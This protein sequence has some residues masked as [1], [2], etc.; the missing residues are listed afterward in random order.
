VTLERSQSRLGFHGIIIDA[1]ERR[2]F[3]E[4]C[5]H[6]GGAQSD[7]ASLTAEDI[8]WQT[9]AVSFHRHKT[10]TVSIIRFGKEV[11][12]VLRTLPQAGPLFPKLQK[13]REGHRA[14]EFKRCCRRLNIQGV[15]L[16]SYR[17]AWAERASDLR[18]P[19]KIRPGGFGAPEQGRASRLRPESPGCDSDP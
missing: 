15:T 16:H 2:A 19:G 13:M 1:Y 9:K 5:W 14:T 17:Y 8:D 11:E 3:Y 6:L 12:S 10:G 7:V 4:F 18:L